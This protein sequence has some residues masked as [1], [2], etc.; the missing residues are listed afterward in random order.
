[1]PSRYENGDMFC[2][3]CSGIGMTGKRKWWKKEDIHT[4]PPRCPECGELLRVKPRASRKYDF[5]GEAQI[6]VFKGSLK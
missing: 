5:E 2:R 4:D 6:L 3:H 1:M